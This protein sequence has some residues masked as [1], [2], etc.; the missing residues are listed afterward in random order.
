MRKIC[1]LAGSVAGL[2][3]GWVAAFGASA[4][5]FGGSYAVTNDTYLDS[6]SPTYNYGDMQVIK[7]TSNNGSGSEFPDTFSRTR[8]LLTLPAGVFSEMG[9]G[10]VQSAT[11]TL[12]FKN[13]SL[14]EPTSHVVRGVVPYALTHDFVAGSGGDPSVSK[15]DSSYT[16]TTHKPLPDNSSGTIFGSDWL[17]YDGVHAWTTPG[18]DFDPSVSGTS[19]IQGTT[20]SI[21]L[22]N[23]LDNATTRGELEA[24][25]LMLQITDE[26]NYVGNVF[27]SMYSADTGTPPVVTVVV[28]EPAGVGMAGVAGAML[29]RR[30]R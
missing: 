6:F 15:I 22:T 5:S 4:V 12:T 10:G 9:S 24:N 13:N 27:A 14:T 1:G 2:V 29:V 23:L 25:G 30:R 3:A 16:V 19:T 26:T 8:A 28:P 21:D 17:T 7:A 20:I 11:I 18:G